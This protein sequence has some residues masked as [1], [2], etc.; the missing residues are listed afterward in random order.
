MVMVVVVV[1]ETAVEVVTLVM[2][3]MQVPTAAVV[4]VLEVVVKMEHGI[5]WQ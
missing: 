4:V 3:E 1:D 2:V 5:R